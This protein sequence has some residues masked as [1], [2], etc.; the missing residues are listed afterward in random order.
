MNNGFTLIELLVV[1][2][3]IGMLIALLLPA[4]QAAREAARRMQ[5]TN[6]F[7]QLGLGLHNHLVTHGTFP[8]GSPN[9]IP[10]G[11]VAPPNWST[12]Q[13]TSPITEFHF[14]WSVF[15]QL[16]PYLEQV[17]IANHVDTTKHCLETPFPYNQGDVFQSLVPSFMCPS[18]QRRSIVIAGD[19]NML[20]Y[21]YEVLGPV[22]YKINMGTGAKVN[23]GKDPPS[24]TANPNGD[25]NGPWLTSLG[26]AYGTDGPF[27][28]KSWFSEAA[29]TDGL[30]NTIFLSESILGQDARGL[31]KATADPR[32]HYLYHQ[33]SFTEIT[34]DNHQDFFLDQ[35]R[36]FR[37]YC[38]NGAYFRSTLYNHYHTPN[39]KLFDTHLNI[40]SH[41]GSGSQ[42]TGLFAARS[43]HRGGVGA[44]R[45][46]GSASFY[47]DS[48]SPVIWWAWATRAG[49]ES[50]GSL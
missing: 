7:K 8:S 23:P 26:P 22:N 39:T 11:Y 15:S 13:V 1:I 4:V 21:G 28:A 33:P 16:T 14:S 45:G 12:G 6:N 10:P 29:I 32:F 5:C 41:P 27:A 35:L 31:T 3:I 49:G 34:E 38:W 47:T 42:S 19:P 20:V 37:G 18:D 50:V 44:L 40:A 48:I 30:S 17:A 9:T 2:A 36:W 46:D 24:P 25:P 43:L